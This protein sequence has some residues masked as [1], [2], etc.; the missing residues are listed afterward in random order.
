MSRIAAPVTKFTRSISTSPAVARPS[1]ILNA[2]S[3]SSRKQ[4]GSETL[5]VSFTPPLCFSPHCSSSSSAPPLHNTAT[6]LWT[7]TETCMNTPIADSPHYEMAWH[8]QT[9]GPF[10]ISHLSSSRPCSICTQF[11]KCSLANDPF[12]SR[13]HHQD[14]Q[15]EI[16]MILTN[17][18][19]PAPPAR[20]L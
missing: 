17:R 10:T 4:S 20:P 19:R 12:H 15:C 16:T 1:H 5:D 9:L 7:T 6:S 13:P 2:T 14:H 8:Y 11:G 18:T 3:N